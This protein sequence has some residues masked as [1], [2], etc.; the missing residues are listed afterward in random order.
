VIYRLRRLQASMQGR[1]AG[2]KTPIDTGGHD[3]I[4]EMAQALDFFVR[5]ISEREAEK[6]R[7]LVELKAAQANLIQAE[8]LASLGQ[9][10]AG[11]AHE[12][13]NPLNF[14]N[15]YSALS[16]ELCGELRVALDIK[17]RVEQDESLRLL[18]RNLN[19]IHD[20]GARAGSIVQSMLA[21]SRQTQT[22]RELVDLNRL[23]DD[24]LNLAW[25]GAR[26]LYQNLGVTV[27]RDF[28]PQPGQVELVPQDISRALLNVLTN[29]FYAV[30]HRSADR[31]RAGAPLVRVAT[32]GAADHVELRITDNGDGM[33]NEVLANLFTP[34]FTTKPAGEGTGLGL[35]LCYD[36]VVRE[37]GGL[38][39]ADS[40]PG[41]ETT[42]VI[43][44]PRRH[45][46][47]TALEIE[48]RGAA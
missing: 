48:A 41:R 36:I 5:T 34:F 31:D 11:V 10:I 30:A 26:G 27:I 18:T 17:D 25:H 1:Q 20:H 47:E 19:K 33:S 15:N 28:A 39:R 2:H 32:S 14:V 44:L 38:I 6:E 46:P 45:C 23:V 16:I 37:H 13:Q 42:I 3:E 7:A 22:E 4:A 29:A 40:I 43:T 9:L 24:A 12:I 8:K 21:H 35:S